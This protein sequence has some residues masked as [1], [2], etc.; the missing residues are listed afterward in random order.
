MKLSNPK[1]ITVRTG[2]NNKKEKCIEFLVYGLSSVSIIYSV[3]IL[4]SLWKQV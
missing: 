4:I 1:L 2:K 3:S